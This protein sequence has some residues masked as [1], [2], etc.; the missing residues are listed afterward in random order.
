[1]TLKKLFPHLILGLA[2]SAFLSAGLALAAADDYTITGDDISSLPDVGGSEFLASSA[3]TLTDV[4]G[5]DFTSDPE[6]L[7]FA[8]N[9]A[10]YANLVFGTL[11]AA[12]LTIAGTCGFDTVDSVDFS[13]GNTVVTITISGGT[14]CTTGQTITIAGLQVETLYAAAGPGNEALFSV[15]NSTTSPGS[16]VDGALVNYSVGVGDLSST[17]VEPGSLEASVS[18]THT[19]SFTTSAPIP[20]LGHIKVTYPSGF[21]VSGVNGQTA[22]SLSGLDGTWTATV[23]GQLVTL[24]QTGGDEASAGAISFTLPNIINPSSEG[25][26]GTYTILTEIAAGN[27]IQTDAAVSADLIVSGTNNNT[28]VLG[29]VSG[30]TVSGDAS[31]ITLNWTDPTGDDSNAVQILRGIDPLPV[32]GT[33]YALVDKGVQTFVDTNVNEGD[34]ITYQIRSA[35]DGQ[36]GNLSEAIVIEVSASGKPEEPTNPE[37]PSNPEEPTNPEE[38]STPEEP[39]NPEFSDTIGHWAQ[40]QIEFMASAGIVQGNP[41]GSFL[42]DG[43]LNRAEAATLIHRILGMGTPSV[44]TLMPFT[45]VAT[46]AWYAGYIA[47]LK[48]AGAVNGNPDGTFEPG[49]S[50]NRAEFLEMAMKAY[51]NTHTVGEVSVSTAYID[52]LTDQWYTAT[53][54]EATE[55]GFVSGSDCEGGKCFRAESFITRAEATVILHRMFAAEL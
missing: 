7:V 11:E 44:P 29:D 51:K 15:D 41:D 2:L 13:D 53:V 25:T 31:G 35:A 6:A 52:L 38:P 4:G 1:M 47:D 28:I 12:D 23:S 21:D 17:N 48:N 10:A 14:S 18:S 43:N 36:Y 22:G 5:D 20:N 27:D 37:E 34:V 55:L 46:D 54:S 19:I 42:P 3:I 16:G 9:G 32:G 26:T 33:T 45:D 30:F 50:I 49:E 40:T 39:T 24:T 8:I